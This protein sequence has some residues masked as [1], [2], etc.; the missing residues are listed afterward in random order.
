M[1]D[2][3]NATFTRGPGG[4]RMEIPGEQ[5]MVITPGP[6]RLE[7]LGFLTFQVAPSSVSFLMQPVVNSTGMDVDPTP[8]ELELQNGM[9]MLVAAPHN[10]HF[11]APQFT[12]DEKYRLGARAP[13]APGACGARGDVGS[14]TDD[15]PRFQQD[16]VGCCCTRL[17]GRLQCVQ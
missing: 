14:E 1:T 11:A 2:E 12:P 13:V 3:Y 5:P 17:Q 15:W 8:V 16:W 6:G 10:V 4:R 7:R 9:L